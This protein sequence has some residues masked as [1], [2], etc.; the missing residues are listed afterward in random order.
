[1]NQRLNNKQKHHLHWS[2]GLVM[3]LYWIDPTCAQSVPN[4]YPVKP[5]KPLPSELLPPPET[6]LELPEQ[7]QL[8][9]DIMQE[10][11]LIVKRFNVVGSTLF[12][13]VEL[14]AVTAPFLNRPLTFSQL[15]EVRSAITQLY[16][17]RGYLTSGAYLPANQSIREG[18]VTIEVVEGSIETIRVTGT[19]SLRPRYI[20]DRLRA[21]TQ[22]PLNVNKLNEALQ[23]LK[24]DP[25][26]ERLSA[27]ILPSP[28][29]GTNVLAVRVVQAPSRELHVQLNNDRSASSGDF[30]RGVS[31]S[32][33]NLTGYGDQ[34]GVNYTNTDGSHEFGASYALPINAKNGTLSISYN[35]ANSKVIQKPFD[36][37]NLRS[38]SRNLTLQFRQPILDKPTYQFAAGVALSRQESETSFF[39]GLP[40]SIPDSGADA[41]G[42][43]RIT[44][45][46][47]FQ[48]WTQQGRRSL[49][50]LRSDFGIG[51]DI[52]A[53]RN[54]KAPDG[55]FFKWQGQAQWLYALR[56]NALLVLRS[57]LQFAD[58]PVPNPALF[59]L[60][61]A[62]GLRGYPQGIFLFD[63]AAL[64]TAA[65]EFSLFQSEAQTHALYLVPFVDVG[66]GWN[67]RK[68]SA[69]QDRVL[70]SPGVGLRYEWSDR[71][72]LQV[73]WGI[74]LIGIPRE[75]IS[76]GIQDSHITI[77]FDVQLL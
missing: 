67:F 64:G 52:G 58:R 10:G 32:Q 1:M 36:A 61:G 38:V 31:F 17:D 39:S 33:A 66:Y 5:P 49:L 68:E 35:Q 8:P 44:E 25:L 50:T 13:E 26:I 65:I 45:M 56:P 72:G 2:L 57:S 51:L 6:L 15:L 70:I 43:T 63:Q 16:L 24:Q 11:T 77:S 74:P 19:K 73:N 60:T 7:P 62:D 41:K 46:N 20:R 21:T 14:Q 3:G 76:P 18:I 22:K 71:I 12:S 28:Q 27:E 37:L 23:V 54:P 34:L 69:T 55:R 30:A 9:P 47:L 75:N 40:F 29:P 42:R 53:T 48:E 4:P 59:S